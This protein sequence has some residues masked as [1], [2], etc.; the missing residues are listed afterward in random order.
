MDTPTA[1]FETT[2]SSF[3]RGLAG[4][5]MISNPSLSISSL[6]SGGTTI[7]LSGTTPG[8]ANGP[9]FSVG[10]IIPGHNLQ[11]RWMIKDA[12]NERYRMRGADESFVDRYSNQ[13]DA[14]INAPSREL[15]RHRGITSATVLCRVIVGNEGES[16]AMQ[17]LLE[18]PVTFT[19]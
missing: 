8:S 17:R 12:A 18:L 7:D 15:L 5:E 2:F 16:G 1:L 11:A 19:W 3:N 9:H 13:L 14:Y 6:S 4:Y 10:P